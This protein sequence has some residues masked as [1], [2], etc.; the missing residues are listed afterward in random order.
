MWVK[1]PSGPEVRHNLQEINN[2]ELVA[3]DCE[4]DSYCSGELDCVEFNLVE[5]ELACAIPVKGRL[6][7]RLDFWK[8]IGASRWVLDVLS[9]GYSLPFIS[10]P[11]R[12]FFQNHHSVAENEDF[13]SHEV[14]KL[15]VSGAIAEVSR[16]DLSVCNPLGVVKNSAG[17]PRLIS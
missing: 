14:S 8:S 7:E 12:A 4:E 3:T 16:E 11:Q 10:L 1:Q 9:D 15:L 13:V 17:K 6:R 2:R 5:V